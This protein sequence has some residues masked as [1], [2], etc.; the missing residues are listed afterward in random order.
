MNIRGHFLLQSVLCI[1]GGGQGRGAIEQVPA[2]PLDPMRSNETAGK[3]AVDHTSRGRGGD[4]VH[5]L[6]L[7]N[8][9]LSIS[10]GRPKQSL[11]KTVTTKTAI[12]IFVQYKLCF[13]YINV[14]H[15]LT[16]CSTSHHGFYVAALYSAQHVSLYFSVPRSTSTCLC[17]CCIRH[18]VSMFLASHRFAHRVT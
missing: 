5:R 18:F 1:A 11:V 6:P 17:L 3:P 9:M 14:W 8:K 15:R 4:T 7:N 13:S 10:G 12:K 16:V 2:R